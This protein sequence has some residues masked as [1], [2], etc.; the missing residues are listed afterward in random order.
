MLKTG[1]EL[2]I[3]GNERPQT[4][5]LDRADKTELFGEK[6]IKVPIFPPQ[7]PTWTCLVLN[8]GRRI[9]TPP[10]DRRSHG[11]SFFMVEQNGRVS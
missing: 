2:T 9:H 11:G 6:P 10:T 7:F 3:P 8:T 5:A 1:F 4:H